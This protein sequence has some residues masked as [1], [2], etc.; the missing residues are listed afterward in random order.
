MFSVLKWIF[1]DERSAFEKEFAEYI[2]AKFV[3]GTSFGRTAL[4]LGLQAVG[5]DKREVIIPSFICTVVRH[6]VVAAGGVPRFVDLNLEDFT[7]NLDDLRR[8]I[9]EKTKV[10]V[11]PHYFGRVARNIHDAISL[12]KEN[13]LILVEDCAHAL[14]AEYKGKKVGTYGDFSVFSLT[15][16]MINFGGGVLVTDNDCIYENAK[17]ILKKEK[18]VLKKRML[19]F[20]IVLA[21]GLEQAVNKVVFDRVSRRSLTWALILLPRF[22]IGTRG[23]MIKALKFPSIVKSANYG[24]VRE[25]SRSHQTGSRVEYEQGVRME[26]IIASLA[27]TQLRKIES[28]E[29]QRKQIHRRVT[30]LASYH[31]KNSDAFPGRDVCTHAV[32]RFPNRDIFRL[33]EKAKRRGLLLRATWPTHQELW[34]EQDTENVTTIGREF[35]TWDVS[36]TLNNQ[37][38]ERFLRIVT[39]LKD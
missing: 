33:V 13:N 10:I 21:Y 27:R 15:K 28:L 2:G 16:N 6:A 12:A 34:E 29:F 7:I 30:T 32:L 24:R 1:S 5:V 11:L 14:G 39:A 35:L 22:I 18:R 36:P 8:K 23:L 19:D 17:K 9:S 38:T 26:P 25:P 4:C 31:F 20:P 37:E 3:I